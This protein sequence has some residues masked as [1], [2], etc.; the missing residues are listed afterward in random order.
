[1]TPSFLEEFLR[2]PAVVGSM[3]PSS[4]ELTEKVMA[5]IDFASAR[6]IVEYGP[7]TGVFTDI[8]IQRRQAETA[9]V[10]VEV[11]R[12]FSKMLKE[13]YSGQPNVHVIHGSADKTGEYLKNWVWIT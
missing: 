8:L 4:R 1:M 12:R 5:P 11:N 2:N 13:R 6:C 9:I 10:L 3:V 7:G